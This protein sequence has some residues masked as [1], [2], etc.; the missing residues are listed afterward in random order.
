MVATVAESAALVSADSCRSKCIRGL[1]QQI[2]L[3]VVFLC[4]IAGA[5]APH[6]GAV[7]YNY[8]RFWLIAALFVFTGFMLRVK[9]LAKGLAAVQVH[10]LCQVYSL[11]VI[12]MSYYLLV[13]RWHW[14]ESIGLLSHEM[15]VGVM[16]AMVMP[17][18]TNTNILWTQMADGDVSIAAVNAVFGNIIGAFIAPMMAS[19]LIGS[20]TTDTNIAHTM[21]SMTQQIILPF[22]IGIA[23]QLLGR[24]ISERTV[25]RLLPWAKHALELILVAITYFMFSAAFEEGA[26]GLGVVSVLLMVFWMLFLHLFYLTAAWFLSSRFHVTRRVAFTITAPQKTENMAVA[27]LGIIFGSKSGAFALPV[28]AYHSLQMVI[29]AVICGPLKAKVAQATMPEALLE[30]TGLDAE[31][32]AVKV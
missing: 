5:V 4:I 31:K 21:W 23:L 15:E 18:T 25:V 3:L 22:F 11:F 1:K 29:A 16:A 17:T 28:V 10:A 13:H 12:P 30:E 32:A 2:P 19:A 20:D 8:C 24:Q 6:P 27:I 7:G 14:T 9:E 26:E